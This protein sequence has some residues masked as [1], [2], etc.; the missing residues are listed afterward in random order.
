MLFWILLYTNPVYWIMRQSIIMSIDDRSNKP[1]PNSIDLAP[2]HTFDD[3]DGLDNVK[4]RLQTVITS[5]ADDASIKT[6]SVLIHG[7]HGNG[8]TR[9]ANAIAGELADE[10]FTVNQ[11]NDCEGAVGEEED[12][13]SE[14]VD[15]AIEAS[16][17][18]LIFDQVSEHHMSEFLMDLRAEL[19]RVQT[20]NEQVLAIATATPTMVGGSVPVDFGLNIE[21]SA[22]NEERTIALVKSYVD[23]FASQCEVGVTADLTD[24]ELLETATGLSATE[25]RLA[26][27]STFQKAATAETAV[28]TEAFASTLLAVRENRP[29]SMMD[30]GPRMTCGDEFIVE[31]TEVSFDNIGGLDEVKAEMRAAMEFPSQFPDVFETC[32]LGTPGMLLFGAP[33]N[34]K[35]MLAKALASEY[36]RTFVVVNGPELKNKY[37]GQTEEN[38]R[39]VF[40]VARRHAPS[41]LFFDE[42]DGLAANRQ[43]ANASHEVDF[44]NTILAELD[45]FRD[46]NDVFVVAATNRPQALDPAIL[47]E[48]RLGRHIHV[49]LPDDDTARDIVEIHTDKFPLAEE[50]TPEWVAA[51]F[52]TDVPAA[53]IT[54]VCD[55]AL[56]WHTMRRA[57]EE[58]EPLELTKADVRAAIEEYPMPE[59]EDDAAGSGVSFY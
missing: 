11:F 15:D 58:G 35:T 13:V 25:L 14:V 16:P 31:D 10:G 18:V 4:E 34:G 23:E 56:R 22:P 39:E 27:K 48:G 12:F 36:D 38:V 29:T 59:Q 28:T 30:Y 26:T 21:L 42:F 52:P 9:L 20:A 49:P 57:T 2:A 5:L 54:G 51:E 24:E 8:K 40:D 41:I 50:V 37:V 3:L 46:T 32:N 6:H 44:V 43:E 7:S 33:G 19:D 55:H 45:G 17:S 1:E 47:R 53:T